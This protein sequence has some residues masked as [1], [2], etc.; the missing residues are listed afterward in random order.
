MTS[1]LIVD[2]PL[3]LRRDRNHAHAHVRFAETAQL[4]IVDR[5]DDEDKDEL[6]YT[7][8]EYNSMIRSIERERDVLQARANDSASREEA[9]SGSRSRLV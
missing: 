9:A 5:H 2:F 3:S 8:A 6:W 7:K 4:H 1:K